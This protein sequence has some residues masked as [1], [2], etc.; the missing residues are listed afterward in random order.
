MPSRGFNRASA[1]VK[2]R[3]N[4]NQTKRVARYETRKAHLIHIQKVNRQISNKLAS[5]LVDL[6]K[7]KAAQNEGPISTCGDPATNVWSPEILEAYANRVAAYTNNAVELKR[8]AHTEAAAFRLR[9]PSSGYRLIDLMLIILM[10]AQTA[11]AQFFLPNIYTPFPPLS[12][13]TP[14]FSAKPGQLS[15]YDLIAS[16]CANAAFLSG[17]LALAVPLSAPFTGPLAVAASTCARAS[18]LAGTS[19]R[20]VN[21]GSGDPNYAL[22]AKNAFTRVGA[23]VAGPL[24]KASGLAESATTLVKDIFKH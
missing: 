18:G 2:I 15:Q 1:R 3:T 22:S 14:T 8:R 21:H 5:E 10:L 19:H 16:R 24:A 13:Y 20:F 7:E 17:G 9:F 6:L 23:H 12:N 4:R 11:Q